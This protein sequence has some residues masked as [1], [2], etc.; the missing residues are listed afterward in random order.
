L[1]QQNSNLRN[2]QLAR[3]TELYSIHLNS[4]S[5]YH[6]IIL[7]LLGSIAETPDIHGSDI[8]QKIR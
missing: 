4:N 5:F 7:S 8:K 1:S 2:Y 6:E 3:S